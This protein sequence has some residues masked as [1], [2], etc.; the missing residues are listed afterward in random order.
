MRETSR[1][2]PSNLS[3]GR[4]L[5]LPKEKSENMGEVRLGITLNTVPMARPLAVSLP[6]GQRGW[7]GLGV[8]VGR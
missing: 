6:P 7:G 5:I 4:N 1:H 3:P 8:S 2:K